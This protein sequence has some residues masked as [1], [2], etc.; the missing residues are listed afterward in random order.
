LVKIIENNNCFAIS[1]DGHEFPVGRIRHNT[2]LLDSPSRYRQTNAYGIDLEV[3]KGIEVD[4]DLITIRERGIDW[5][6][7]KRFWREHGKVYD[8]NNGRTEMFL[9]DRLFGLDKAKAYEDLM[10]PEIQELLQKDVF[11]IGIETAHEG[12]PVFDKLLKRWLEAI[13]IAAKYAQ[14]VSVPQKLEL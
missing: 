7:S 6:T 1:Y 8:L 13:E 9:P 14:A 12:W 11:D 2:L 4:Y 10:E 5:V 3:L